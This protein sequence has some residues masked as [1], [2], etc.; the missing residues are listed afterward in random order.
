MTISKETLPYLAQGILEIQRKG[1]PLEA[2][3]AQGE[4]WDEHDAEIYKEQLYSLMETY[5]QNPL[6]PPINI[7]ARTI[8]IRPSSDIKNEVQKTK[9]KI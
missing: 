7:L 5:L 4:N 8:D 9:N 3:L 6:L 2:A 1:Y